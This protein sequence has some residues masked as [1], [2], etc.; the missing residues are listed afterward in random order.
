MLQLLKT[1]LLV[2]FNRLQLLA[3]GL[4]PRYLVGSAS[5]APTRYRRRVKCEV[6]NCIIIKSKWYYTENDRKSLLALFLK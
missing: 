4:N 5:S 3:G 1:F 6:T 2:G